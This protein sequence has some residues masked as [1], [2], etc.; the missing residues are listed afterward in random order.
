M[1]QQWYSGDDLGAGSGVVTKFKS[2]YEPEEGRRS[3]KRLDRIVLVGVVIVV[4]IAL[5][6][7][8]FTN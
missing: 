7:Y 8:L 2:R 3:S 5:Y 6:L 1:G 4:G